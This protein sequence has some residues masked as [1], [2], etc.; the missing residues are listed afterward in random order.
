MAVPRG[1]FGLSKFYFF[2]HLS[3]TAFSPSDTPGAPF[4]VSFGRRPLSPSARPFLA[5]RIRAQVGRSSPGGFAAILPLRFPVASRGAC[6]PAQRSLFCPLFFASSMPPSALFSKELRHLRSGFGTSIAS[7]ASAARSPLPRP[8]TA[9]APFRFP[10]LR[11]ML[12]PVALRSL[13]NRCSPSLLFSLAASPSPLLSRAPS[14]ASSSVRIIVPL[15]SLS[16]T[17]A[18]AR[19]PPRLSFS[20]APFAFL[21]ALWS[22]S[23]LPR[24]VLLSLSV[25]SSILPFKRPPLF[26]NLLF[27]YFLS[28]YLGLNI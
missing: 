27:I 6:A 5:H 2:L 14:S 20:R 21:T 24:S 17:F 22:H 4:S 15:W 16:S 13:Q 19:P 28:F 9:F 23:R 10:V 1:L 8:F 12:S 3:L 25:S 26:S 11:S 18:I 7:P